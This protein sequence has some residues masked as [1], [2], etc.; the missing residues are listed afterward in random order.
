LSSTL[1]DSFKELFR[2]QQPL[3]AC[4]F[5][6]RHVIVT[7]VD[8]KRSRIQGR[9]A[10]GIPDDVT[11]QDGDRFKPI[12]EESLRTASFRGSEIVLV[13]PDEAARIAFVTAEALPR[14]VE[15][16]NTFLR[17][18]LKKTLPFDVDTAQIAFRVLRALKPSGYDILVALSPRNVIQQYEALME[19][20]DIHAGF[21]IPSTLAALNLLDVP[22]E[23]TLFVKIAPDCI[24]TTVFQDKHMTFYRRV[25]ELG[26]YES[27]Y[28]TVLYYQ[29]K[30]GGTAFKQMI[31][32]GYNEV[33]RS[34]IA[35]LQE[36]MGMPALALQPKRVDD[37]Y[38]PALG[39]VHLSWANLI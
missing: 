34:A 17:W 38:K 24:T 3:W 14:T 36:K 20:L 22:N 16:Q 11:I 23:D 32:C 29:D 7:G 25:A 2:P 5:T 13:V 27:V 19:K 35:E 21:V 26:V 33:M 9:T 12:L 31:V 10:T 8:G 30:L 39:A 18:K 15:E 37:I 4:E 28:P 1:T 6:V